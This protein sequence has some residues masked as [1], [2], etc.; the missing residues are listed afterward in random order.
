[1]ETMENHIQ[2]SA[3][4]PCYE[5]EGAAPLLAREIRGVF[6][7]LGRPFEIIFVDDASTDGTV[8]AL[9]QVKADVPELVIVRHG[10]N[11]GQSAAVASGI[12][13]AQGD[14]V[15]TMDGDGQNDPADIP[16]LL[17]LLEGADVVCGVRTR[18]QDSFV[19]R[20]SSK[21]GNGFR[22]IVTRD[23][24][25]DTG[26][27]LRVMRREALAELPVFNGVHRFLPS[28]LRVQGYRVIEAPVGH[29]PR[30]MG[31]SKY[32]IG[33]R[34]LRGLVDCLAML[35]WRR[36]AIPARR[37]FPARRQESSRP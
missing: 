3:I 8:G 12:A 28:I 29:R 35:W 15:V 24:V 4:V 9:E 16:G 36:R 23:A 27:A 30:T 17:D 26:C 10:F 2:I 13:A 7:D 20:C 21:I 33:N 5:E 34:L 37:L 18:R 19:R 14:V 6:S 32:G 11:C 31:I 22:N 1:M 25:T